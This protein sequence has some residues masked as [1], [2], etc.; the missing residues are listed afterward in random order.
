MLSPKDLARVRAAYAKRLGQLKGDEGER[1]CGE[2][3]NGGWLGDAVMT[4][5]SQESTE[6]SVAGASSRLR[7]LAFGRDGRK[8]GAK[9]RVVGESFDRLDRFEYREICTS[10]RRDVG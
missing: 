7:E 5:D 6:A 4:W 3:G 1:G 8:R 9:G 10:D 2:R